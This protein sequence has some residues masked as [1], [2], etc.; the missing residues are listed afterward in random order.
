MHALSPFVFI[1]ATAADP[2]PPIVKSRKPLGRT[3]RTLSS[4]RGSLISHLAATEAFAR[5][6]EQAHRL[7]H[8][9]TL[10]ETALPA[11]LLPGTHVANIKQGKLIIHVASGAVAVKLRQ[12]APRL[13][14]SFLQ[15][16][17]EVTGIEVKVQAHRRSVASP[18]TKPHKIIGSRPKEALRSLASGLGEDSPVKQALL[19]LLQNA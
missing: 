1:T 16:G 12:M 10:L 14:A 8:I 5:L 17:Q 13:A 19:K 6:S 4:D 3:P 9:Q 2:M 11:S 15:Q 7:R 18:S